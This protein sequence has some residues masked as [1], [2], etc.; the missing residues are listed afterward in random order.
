MPATLDQ[1][2]QMQA[3]RDRIADLLEALSESE[4][5]TVQKFV[6][7]LY[8]AAGLHTT[9]TAPIDDEPET[10]AERAAVQQA[11][12]SIARGEKVIPHEALRRELGL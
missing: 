5:V 4:L 12:D 6:E 8:H 11:R 7:F 2:G 1:A 3:I 9:E 10:A